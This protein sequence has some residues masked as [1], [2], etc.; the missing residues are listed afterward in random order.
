MHVQTHKVT[1]YISYKAKSMVDW[2]MELFQKVWYI[3]EKKK[4]KKKKKWRTPEP[5]H[6]EKAGLLLLPVRFW[7]PW[8]CCLEFF[9]LLLSTHYNYNKFQSNQ[10]ISN[11]NKITNAG[12]WELFAYMC[13][14]DLMLAKY[15]W[16]DLRWTMQFIAF[17][18]NSCAI[19]WIMLPYKQV[20]A[21]STCIQKRNLKPLSQMKLAFSHSLF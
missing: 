2:V 16:G 14:R 21:P 19:V 1:L 17:F 20:S 11:D 7:L 6:P 3:C 10:Y 15:S 5:E 9:L 4:R 8:R 12:E 18:I 13:L